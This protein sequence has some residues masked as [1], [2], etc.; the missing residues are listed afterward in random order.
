S[1]TSIAEFAIRIVPES[2]TDR[3][4]AVGAGAGFANSVAPDRRSSIAVAEGGGSSVTSDEGSPENSVITASFAT[5]DCGETVAIR[6]IDDFP[7]WTSVIKI[8]LSATKG[9][10]INNAIPCRPRLTAQLDSRIAE[11][12]RGN[13]SDMSRSMS[14]IFSIHP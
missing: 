12:E 1:L 3:P 8:G 2:A 9:L 4:I 14:G 6:C 13:I 5:D 10:N 11:R 7:R